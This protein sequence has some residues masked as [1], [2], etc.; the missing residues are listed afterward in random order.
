LVF[1]IP[2]CVKMCEAGINVKGDIAHVSARDAVR[3]DMTAPLIRLASV[4]E[5]YRR[6]W[7]PNPFWLPVRL[8]HP[9]IAFEVL[10]CALYRVINTSFLNRVFLRVSGVLFLC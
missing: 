3:V 2:L 8:G 6:K 5:T 10:I 1:A 9:A 4:E 7:P